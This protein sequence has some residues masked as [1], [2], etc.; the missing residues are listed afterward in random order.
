[1]PKIRVV[2]FLTHTNDVAVE[3]LAQKLAR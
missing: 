2:C 3:D 1:M